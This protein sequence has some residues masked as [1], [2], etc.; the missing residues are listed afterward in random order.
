MMEGMRVLML[1]SLAMPVLSAAVTFHRDVTPVLQKHCQE[2]HR[3]GE[4]APMP[5]MTYADA[6]PWAKAIKTAVLNGKMPPWSAS[7]AHGRFRND[8]SLTARERDIL[9]QWADQ[10]AVEGAAH[11]AP[12]PRPFTA[13]WRIGKPDLII[14]MPEEFEVPASGEIPYQFFRVDP[15]FTADR[16]V[17]A[18]EVRPSERSVVHHAIVTTSRGGG[19]R[20]QEYLGG[21]AP[22][23]V[24]QVWPQGQAR[25]IRAGSDLIFQMHYTANG[26]VA[27]DR[28]RIGLIFSSQPVKQR[29]VALQASAYWL[30]IPP[31]AANHRT[32]SAAVM[33]EEVD[34][35][36]M[37][38]HM[39]LR[40]KSFQFRAV[41]P[42]GESEILL[43]IPRYDFNWQPYYY[44]AQPKRLPRG[45]R[46]ECTAHFDNSANNP[47]NPDP[48]AT[49][50]WGPQTWEEM[51]IGWIDVA[52]DVERMNRVTTRRGVIE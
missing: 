30:S 5:L 47:A 23:A 35:V 13:G 41:Y 2:C 42:T 3:A 14:E 1:L 8:P 19:W 49:V 32:N 52:V 11:E 26:K 36:G 40:G 48:T 27:R 20:G 28:T 10:G 38:A 7:P 34:L 25:L 37:R 43:D 50:S 16:W 21:Y 51:M 31:G 12:P 33:S 6:R 44:L 17:Q 46:I 45:T 18:L 22:G 9:V 15:G 24:A 39:H 4:A 29:V